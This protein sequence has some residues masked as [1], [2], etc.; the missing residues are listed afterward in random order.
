MIYSV[1]EEPANE[2]EIEVGPETPQTLEDLIAEFKGDRPD[3]K[4]FAVKLKAMV[5]HFY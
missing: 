1:L 4:T 2:T 3:A 5:W